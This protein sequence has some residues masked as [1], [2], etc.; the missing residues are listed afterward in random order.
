MSA[1]ERRRFRAS[2]LDLAAACP[3]RELLDLYG[4]LCLE[5]GYHPDADLLEATFEGRPPDDD[6]TDTAMRRAQIVRIAELADEREQ[7]RLRVRASEER[8]TAAQAQVERLMSEVAEAQRSAN[9][10]MDT[11]SHCDWSCEKAHPGGVHERP[12]QAELVSWT[13]GTVEER[14][15]LREANAALL[16]ELNAVNRHREE[17][18]ADLNAIWNSESWK[19]GRAVTWPVRFVLR[20]QTRVRDGSTARSFS[21]R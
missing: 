5:A 16:E 15:R 11:S 21:D 4:L 12:D 14:E 9:E 6:A 2:V 17:L 20:R 7:F 1:P 3:P 13:R 18:V 10:Q 19:L 8:C